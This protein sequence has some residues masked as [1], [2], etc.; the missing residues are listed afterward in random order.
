MADSARL[1][2]DFDGCRHLVLE[3]RPHTLY[4]SVGPTGVVVRP[5]VLDQVGA[6]LGLMADSARATTTR[7]GGSGRLGSRSKVSTTG[8]EPTG[9]GRLH[10]LCSRSP[11]HP[12]YHPSAITV[13]YDTLNAPGVTMGPYYC[14]SGVGGHVRY[15]GFWTYGTQEVQASVPRYGRPDERP[16]VHRASP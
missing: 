15:R 9:G 12:P 14:F 16:R 11:T 1:V 6:W 2:G 8:S 10:S 4:L 13:A 3:S 5:T 7:R